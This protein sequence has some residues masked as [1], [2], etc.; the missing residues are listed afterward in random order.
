LTSTQGN[1]FAAWLR[2]SAASDIKSTIA[3][4]EKK[5]DGVQATLRAALT[6]CPFGLLPNPPSAI[7][8]D[9]MLPVTPH[10]LRQHVAGTRTQHQRRNSKS[11]P[12][13]ETGYFTCSTS[14]LL[15]LTQKMGLEP[16][17]SSLAWK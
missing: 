2:I 7:Q 8:D 14:E 16:M 1:R 17:T 12:K 11:S 3:L 13:G 9:A 15:P 4:H 5:M 10:T 6:G